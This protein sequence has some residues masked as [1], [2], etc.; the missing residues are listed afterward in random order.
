MYSSSRRRVLV[1]SLLAGV[2]GACGLREEAATGVN[3]AELRADAALDA[4]GPIDAAPPEGTFP[5]SWEN[6]TTCGSRP[7]V[8]V[9]AHTPSTYILRQSICTNFEA[10]FIYL[11][12]GGSRAI[13]FDS[14]TGDADVRTAVDRLVESWRTSHGLPA[15]DL[16]VAHTHSH[17]DHV[18]GDVQFSSRPH[19]Q[20]VGRQPQQVA[21][22]FGLSSWPNGSSTFALGDRTLR[23]VPLPGHEAAHIAVYDPEAQLLLT[24][25]TLY[26]GRLYIQSWSSYRASVQR[27]ADFVRQENLTVRHVLGAHIEYDTTGQDYEFQALT[28]PDEHPLPLGIDQLYELNDAVQ[29]M[30][31]TPRHERH[32]H[33]YIYP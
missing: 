15:V 21:A 16:V 20:I 8:E 22:F 25:D 32:S 24:G 10:P 12:F 3:P 1:M 2:A 11:L 14:G 17:G 28:H 9:W 19:T 23:V 26:P 4:D 13:M 29:R 18:R 33:F 7:D 31:T 5:K 6:G 27:L 30:G